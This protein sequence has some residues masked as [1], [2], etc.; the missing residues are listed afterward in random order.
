M[1]FAHGVKRLA[2]YGRDV[3]TFVAKDVVNMSGKRVTASNTWEKRDSIVLKEYLH[4][5]KGMN[6]AKR[7]ELSNQL[8]TIAAYLA[9][10]FVKVI[11]KKTGLKKTVKFLK[12]RTLALTDEPIRFMSVERRFAPTDKFIRFSNNTTYE[13]MEKKAQALGVDS[14]FV[15]LVTAFSHWTHQV[16]SSFIMV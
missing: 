9:I 12:I 4:R 15:Q 5:G 13:I 10:K 11:E 6:S 8:Q 2:F 3:S 16:L 1:P 7:Y 14:D